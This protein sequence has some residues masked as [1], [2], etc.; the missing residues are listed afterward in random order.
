MQRRIYKDWANRP[1]TGH[2]L[3][4]GNLAT[5]TQEELIKMTDI[6][7]TAEALYGTGYAN[8]SHSDVAEWVRNAIR[9]NAKGA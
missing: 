3:T 4:A 8:S 1:T 9:R 7:E 2:K 6:R 5:I